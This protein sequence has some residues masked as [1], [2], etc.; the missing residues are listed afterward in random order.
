MATKYASISV[1]K[2]ATLNALKSAAVATTS[3]HRT[4]TFLY[5]DLNILSVLSE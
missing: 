5:T 4:I 1:V 2:T 3:T